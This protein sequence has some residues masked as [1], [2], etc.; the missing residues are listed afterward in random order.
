MWKI[1]VM[2]I[3]DEVTSHH[4]VDEHCRLLLVTAVTELVVSSAAAFS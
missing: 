2:R 4:Q 3:P 1:S